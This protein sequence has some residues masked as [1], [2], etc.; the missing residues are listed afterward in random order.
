LGGGTSLDPEEQS[1]NKRGVR[2]GFEHG[3]VTP[4]QV[5]RCVDAERVASR[6]GGVWLRVWRSS[7]VVGEGGLKTRCA[8][9]VVV[10]GHV[11]VLLQEF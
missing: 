5:T 10:G 11:A 3:L 7:R 1:A 8:Q 9:T 6:E 4:T 2:V